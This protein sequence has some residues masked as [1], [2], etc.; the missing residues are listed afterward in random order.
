VVIDC[1]QVEIEK[2]R[3]YAPVF[4]RKDGI[5]WR[6][7]NYSVARVMQDCCGKY[8]NKLTLNLGVPQESIGPG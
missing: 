2:T 5:G 6:E 8:K 7:L 4:N 1:R 3:V